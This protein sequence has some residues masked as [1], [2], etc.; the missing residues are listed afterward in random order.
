MPDPDEHVAADVAARR[1]SYI[2]KTLGQRETAE[3]E[4]A[5]T[6]SVSRFRQMVGDET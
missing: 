1:D 4:P 2:D 3:Q 6:P 5:A